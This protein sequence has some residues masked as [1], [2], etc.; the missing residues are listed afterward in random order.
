MN[1]KLLVCAIAVLG[2][3]ALP[4]VAMATAFTGTI[5][6]T[7]DTVSSDWTVATQIAINSGYGAGTAVAGARTGTF[8]AIAF[9]AQL[10]H[11][12]PLIYD[13]V[14]GSLP[15]TPL[16]SNAATGIAFNLTSLSV[17]Q[18]TATDIDLKGSGMFT[19]LAGVNTCNTMGLVD[20]PGS[21]ALSAQDNGPVAASFS[22]SQAVVPEPGT[23][24][25]LGLGLLGL[26]YR[27][28]RRS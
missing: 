10:D 14:G 12:S 28:R 2:A 11:L 27:Q 24:T 5:N 8:T 26:A 20:T 13:P 3:V 17:T 16:W 25:L 22:A 4:Q 23:I 6:Y 18:R 21:W 7:G 1:R 15:A 9:L 19:C